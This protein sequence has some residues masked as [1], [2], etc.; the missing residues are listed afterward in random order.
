[1]VSS[2][3]F[4]RLVLQFAELV[5]LVQEGMQVENYK[6]IVFFTT[7]RQVR[8]SLFLRSRSAFGK[9]VHG[10]VLRQQ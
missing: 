6:V 7:A 9:T 3:C 10:L 2:S 4:I 5:G 1:M 8:L